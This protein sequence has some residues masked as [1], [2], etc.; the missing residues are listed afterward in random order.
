MEIIVGMGHHI[1]LK[2][3]LDFSICSSYTVI[4]ISLNNRPRVNLPI[5]P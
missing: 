5:Q 1:F 2:I 4:K 3:F